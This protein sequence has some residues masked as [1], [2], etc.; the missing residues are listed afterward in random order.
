MASRMERDPNATAC[1]WRWKKVR[2]QG[3]QHLL[4][5]ARWTWEKVWQNRGEIMT[6][7]D[8]VRR[9]V[10]MMCEEKHTLSTESKSLRHSKSCRHEQ[11][12][13]ETVMVNNVLYQTFN[14]WELKSCCRSKILY[15]QQSDITSTCDVL[16]LLLQLQHNIGVM[17]LTSKWIR[18]VN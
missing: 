1:L 7:G 5:H 13:R 14:S 3:C 18:C 15:L 9:C 17:A 8:I 16:C 6:W 10:F 12:W 4:T 11:A 2:L